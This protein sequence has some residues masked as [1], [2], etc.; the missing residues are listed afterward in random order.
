MIATTATATATLSPVR[1][2]RIVAALVASFAGLVLGREWGSMI[3]GDHDLVMRV[4]ADGKL[5]LTVHELD[6][7][8]DYGR[9]G[10]TAIVQRGGE[11]AYEVVRPDG[12]VLGEARGLDA[13]VSIALGYVVAPLRAPQQH[14]ADPC[15]V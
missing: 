15:G 10:R 6:E 2:A 9:A 1:F 3:D 12:Y 4:P 5:A 7:A 14:E 11:R 13:A 8:G